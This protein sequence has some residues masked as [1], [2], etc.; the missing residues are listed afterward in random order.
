MSL[1]NHFF[2]SPVFSNT[3]FPNL[4]LKTGRQL[5]KTRSVVA[6]LIL[7]KATHPGH[8]NLIV[9]PLQEQADRMSSIIFRPLLDDSPIK[10]LLGY[11]KKSS[12][13][14][15]V[16]RI[17]C[18]NGSMTHFQYTGEDATRI[19]QITADWVYIDE[20]QD[21]LPDQIPIVDQC[22]SSRIFPTKFISGTS[23]SH[24]TY[25]EE[26]W[27]KSSQGIWHIDC[28][29]C[30]FENI[31]CVEEKGGHLQKML[32]P[33]RDDI[34]NERPGLVCA[35]CQQPVH[36]KFGKWVH[37]YPERLKDFPGYYIPQP[38]SPVHCCYPNK[39]ADLVGRWNGKDNY[40]IDKFYNEI[41]GEA[42]DN[43][44]TL[45]GVEDLKAVGILGPNKIE[46]AASQ[47]CNYN[48]NVL[49][50]DWGGGGA[51]GVS[52][53]KVAFACFKPDG[54]VDVLYGADFPP[55]TDFLGEAKR[56][57][58]IASKLNVHYIAHDYN[59]AISREAFLNHV[60]WSLDRLIPIVYRQLIGGD[61]IEYQKPLKF[62]TRG[63]YVLDKAASLQL[64]CSYIRSRKIKFFNYDYEGPNQ[65]GLLH[66]FLNLV[67]EKMETPNGE[68]YRVR[69][70]TTTCSDD[71][72]HAVNYAVF[73]GWNLTGWW[74]S[75]TGNHT[76]QE[77]TH[78]IGAF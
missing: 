29:H 25:L 18:G 62:R 17:V 59:G 24:Q 56:I 30:G 61:I 27:A 22:L 74:S 54:T 51:E 73:A 48:F 4:V 70:A 2:F 32:G 64:L 60:G 41:L 8:I 78:A 43:A 33:I 15:S 3:Y 31:C 63:Y 50:V 19:R 10:K 58:E 23:K 5:G 68:V 34:S 1:R 38:I 65:P 72:A 37:R 46:H 66:D 55:S 75:M 71:F 36:P 52:R 35:Q 76:V 11:D 44:F 67:E 9:Y 21:H 49:G 13:N 7:R 77:I 28:P 6:R 40:T 53:T 12:L 45:V 26:N 47:V 42:Y 57:T 69:K 20:A 16:R 39:W 14:A